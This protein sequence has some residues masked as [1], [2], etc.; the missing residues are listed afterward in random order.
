MNL[1]SKHSYQGLKSLLFDVGFILLYLSFLVYHNF[2]YLAHTEAAI[3]TLAFLIFFL[4]LLI[5]A[6]KSLS[7]SHLKGFSNWLIRINQLFAIFLITMLPIYIYEWPRGANHFTL[8]TFL[9][10]IFISIY[11]I[12]FLK[13]GKFRL[14]LIN[15]RIYLLCA[16][17]AVYIM[18]ALHKL[19]F[20]FYD[21][22][23]SCANWYHV[24]LLK[25]FFISIQTSDLPWIISHTSPNM[26]GIIEVVSPI[27][28][29]F[30]STRIYGLYFLFFLHSYLALGGF[31]DFSSL[32]FAILLLFVPGFKQNTGLW[33]KNS[34]VYFS[35]SIFVIPLCLIGRFVFLEVTTELQTLQGLILI[36]AL[37]YFLYNSGTDSAVSDLIGYRFI[38]LDLMLAFQI[39]LLCVYAMMPY[40]GFKASGNFT[41]FSNLKIVGPYN[42]HFFMK[43]FNLF[44]HDKKLIQIKSVKPRSFLMAG[45][46]KNDWMSKSG[47]F[48]ALRSFEQNRPGE[49]FEIKFVED[50]HIIH[51]DQN[52]I[53]NHLG[54][55]KPWWFYKLYSYS[56]IPDQTNLLDC[57]W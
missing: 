57:R 11:I 2:R 19:N 32:A 5:G 48:V 46:K 26:V 56:Y 38:R 24:K 30:K 36:L 33:F 34:V 42:N 43:K 6:K 40:Y 51:L 53:R 52:N 29:I 22:I 8:S 7:R 13:R 1:K 9:T 55:R 39:L 18:A 10:F 35:A 20:D 49:N 50:N 21:P 12:N 4:G 47:L 54:T 25:R 23:K 14:N 31:S 3:L 16:M 28:L 45:R 17:I 15:Y 37:S 41:M 27:L 44:D